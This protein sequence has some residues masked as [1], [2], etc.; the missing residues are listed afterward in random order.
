M[1]EMKVKMKMSTVKKKVF[2]HMKT[3]LKHLWTIKE[4]QRK[5]PKSKK[6][7]RFRAP[8]QQKLVTTDHLTTGRKIINKDYLVTTNKETP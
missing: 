1:Q 4:L 7:I 5:T 6:S 3:I 8:S 2:Y